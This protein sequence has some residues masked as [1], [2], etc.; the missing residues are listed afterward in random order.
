MV[1][2]LK[3]SFDDNK[4]K[5][6]TCPRCG[7]KLIKDNKICPN[8]GFNIE[9]EEADNTEVLSFGLN[10]AS[11][12]VNDV[13]DNGSEF[14]QVE[15]LKIKKYKFIVNI[16]LLLV[17]IFGICMMFLP[18][19][20]SGNFWENLETVSNLYGI[21][22]DNRLSFD[23]S[24][25]LIS[26]ISNL[27][28]F[29]F[30]FAR[31]FKP[32]YLMYFYEAIIVLA[33]IIIV[34]ISVF[35]LAIAIRNIF[36]KADMVNYRTLL[37]VV[38]LL[39]LFI[40]FALN[41]FGI[42]PIILACLCIT[43]FIMFY[44]CGVV[45]KEKKFFPH[46]LLH[47]SLTFVALLVLLFI[48]NFGLVRLNV[49]LGANLYNGEDISTITELQET[50]ICRGLF[51]EFATFIQCSSKVTTFSSITYIAN[52]FTLL[53][54]LAYIVLIIIAIGELLK[55]LSKQSVRFPIGFII[56][57]TIAFYVFSLAS[58]TLIQTIDDVFYSKYLETKTILDLLKVESYSVFFLRGGMI[59]SLVLF[60]P[61]CAYSIVASRI[62]L[63]K[64]YR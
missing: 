44:V 60:A 14:K 42:G 1:S 49:T 32:L 52:T 20:G 8:C 39:D 15:T 46:I 48:S 18:I 43:C 5:I 11:I 22:K 2:S 53:F 24:T 50:F 23:S 37:E 63:N 45:S 28:N 33:I 27:G 6:A 54:H 17:G 41:C 16:I 4:S 21:G 3:E 38:M 13:T 10:T 19:F 12:V 25:N 51:Y 58:F 35:I 61:I 29:Q 7:Q 47:K 26:L 55:S 9:K 40:I 56:A 30:L 64:N 62:C 57:S 31:V 36:F 59:G 34:C